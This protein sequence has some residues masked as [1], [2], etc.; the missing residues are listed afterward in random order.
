MKKWRGLLITLALVVFFSLGFSTL[1]VR[2]E[3]AKK[4]TQNIMK[5]IKGSKTSIKK[6]WLSDTDKKAYGGVYDDEAFQLLPSM[7]RYI[8][9][10][11]AKMTYKVK[12]IKTKG[13]RASV[14]VRVRYAD[15]A[16]LQKYFLELTEKKL[17]ELTQ[18]ELERQMKEKG[19]DPNDFEAVFGFVLELEFKCMSD[20]FDEA[21]KKYPNPSMKTKTITVQL[22]KSGSK[23]KIRELDTYNQSL[24]KVMYAG[25]MEQTAQTDTK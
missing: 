12:T 19:I 18:E 4:S 2:A 14:K 8:V 16:K 5:Y 15:S 10:Q 13:S 7:K 3:T 9:K 20:A 22:E 24:R 11:N 17:G 23:W 25:L 21:V 1:D 6:Y